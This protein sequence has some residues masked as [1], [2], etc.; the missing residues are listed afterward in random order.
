MSKT[1]LDS[2][3]K[4]DLL[5]LDSANQ[6][7]GNFILT[8]KEG[9]ITQLSEDKLT[10]ISSWTI[11]VDQ[12]RFEVQSDGRSIR[13]GFKRFIVDPIVTDK[14]ISE[15][16]RTYENRSTSVNGRETQTRIERL[17]SAQIDSGSVSPEKQSEL[18]RLEAIR[19]TGL[20]SARELKLIANPPSS[21]SSPRQTYNPPLINFQA[22]TYEGP[23]PTNAFAIISFILSLFGGSLLAVIFGHIALSQIRK[24]RESGTGLA[25]AG[26][27]IGYITIFIIA[28]FVIAVM[29]ASSEVQY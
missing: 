9:V 28:I 6:I 4:M 10:E 17:S 12:A 23:N 16:F 29:N 18:D 14:T 19:A 26:L 11:Q 25:Q 7:A 13:I 21:T 3:G 2:G 5:V 1:N 22:P 15:W 27:I 8:A 24:T 20:L